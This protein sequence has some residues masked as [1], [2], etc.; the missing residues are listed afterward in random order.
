MP[1]P[2][3]QLLNCFQLYVEKEHD[4]LHNDQRNQLVSSVDQGKGLVNCL[5]QR[6]L[7]AV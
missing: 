5:L 4:Q 1:W 2:G 7:I 6:L 3:W